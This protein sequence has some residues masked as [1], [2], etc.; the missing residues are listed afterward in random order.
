MLRVVDLWHRLAAD[1]ADALR[2]AAAN[3]DPGEVSAVARLRKEWPADLVRIAIDLARAQRALRRKW[4]D[5][6]ERL[7]ADPEGAEMASSELTA[8]HK[9]ARFLSA[10]HEG[11]VLDLCSGIG[12]DTIALAES[13]PDRCEAIELDEARA[14]MTKRNAGVRCAVQDARKA[15]VAGALLHLDPQRR[16]GAG[17]RTRWRF[18]EH[19]PGPDTIARV[20]HEALGCAV[21]LGPGLDRED[22]VFRSCLPDCEIEILS[23]HG[24]LTQA[25]AWTGLLRSTSGA[26]ATLLSDSGTVTFVGEPEH[27]GTAPVQDAGIGPW[28]YEPDP[29]LER[30]GL[31]A[32][33]CREHTLATVHPG[34]GVLHGEPGLESPW[35]TS[36]E[37][38]ESLPWQ[39]K[40]VRAALAAQGAGIVEVKTRGKA[41]DPDAEQK[42]LRGDGPHTLTVFVLRLGDRREAFI[43]RRTASART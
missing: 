11:P 16:T 28:L 25:V 36:F 12:A 37:V 40:R 35:L 22:P 6:A 15:L 34:L 20:A 18:D 30:A 9:A 13:A 2:S 4:P 7:L 42:R 21:K 38:L 32:A 23:E 43:T 3:A 24:S 10:A 8:R 1:D 26:R 31:L 39:P 17:A 19:E 14:F 33:F 5:R 27:W 41:I 29:S